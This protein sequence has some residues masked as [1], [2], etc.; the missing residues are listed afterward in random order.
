[1]TVS[2]PVKMVGQSEGVKAGG[3]LVRKMRKL[4]VSGMVEN[5]PEFFELN[6]EKMNIGD[7]IR[8]GTMEYADIAFLDN[9][10]M[11]IVSIQTSR[12]VV[13]DATPAA[14]A[15]A[16]PAAAKAAPAAAAAKAPAKK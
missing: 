1:M 4:R 6:I 2:I 14:A 3:K 10:N 15:K 16:A 5:I 12:N 13:A 8:V 7:S 11:T 9:K